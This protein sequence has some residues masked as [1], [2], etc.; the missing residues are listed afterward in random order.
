MA[1]PHVSGIAASLI[2]HYPDFRG[3]P[4]LL[5]AHL[6]ASTVLHREEVLPA[7]NNSGGRND[8]GLG[9]LVGLS[10]ALGTQQSER[11]DNALGVVGRHHQQPLGLLGISPFRAE[12]IGSSSS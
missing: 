2:Q 9:R 12:P 1:T 4:H 3:R 5:R 11:L 6:M 7:N 10:G 8:F